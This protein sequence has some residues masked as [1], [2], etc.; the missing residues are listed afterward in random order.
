MFRD[1]SIKKKLTVILMTAGTVA[2]LLAC[3]VFMS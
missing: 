3:I 2:V 1:M